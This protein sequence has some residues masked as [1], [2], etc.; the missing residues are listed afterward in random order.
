MYAR[1]YVCCYKLSTENVSTRS[2]IFVF[3]HKSGINA[4]SDIENQRTNV[5]RDRNQRFRS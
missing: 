3:K 5:G 2:S 4:Y 1:M